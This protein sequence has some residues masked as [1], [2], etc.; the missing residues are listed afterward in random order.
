MLYESTRYSQFVQTQIEKLHEIRVR[1][2]LM[3]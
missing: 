1:P 3:E 2:W